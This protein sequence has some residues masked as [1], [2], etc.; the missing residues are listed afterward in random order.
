[1]SPDVDLSADQKGFQEDLSSKKKK[2]KEEFVF[3][4]VA[5]FAS[6]F[7]RRKPAP[8]FEIKRYDLLLNIIYVFWSKN[9]SAFSLLS[10]KFRF[11]IW[12][13]SV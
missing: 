2:E 1:M 3:L 11:T 4:S 7:R 8:F 6:I 10:T 5:E 9:L 12:P 13:I